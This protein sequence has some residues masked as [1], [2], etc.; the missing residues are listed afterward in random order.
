MCQ[1]AFLSLSPHQKKLNKTVSCSTG[2][3][4]EIKKVFSSKHSF[5]ESRICSWRSAH[6]TRPASSP[7]FYTQKLYLTKFIIKFI[8][9]VLILLVDANKKG[10][11]ASFFVQPP[12]LPVLPPKNDGFTW[13]CYETFFVR[14][15]ELNL[16]TFYVLRRSNSA[17]SSLYNPHRAPAEVK[18][19]RNNDF[20]RNHYKRCTLLIRA[21]LA[22]PLK[23]N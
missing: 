21:R 23:A 7:N 16:F 15:G 3:R 22:A 12:F 4:E 10:L 20:H 17:N 13:T 18:R 19:Y 6:I 1:L 11:L 2:G 9:I 5:W 14:F 8:N